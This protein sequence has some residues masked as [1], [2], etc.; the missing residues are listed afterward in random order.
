V[1]DPFPRQ[2]RRGVFDHGEARIE[3]QAG[4]TIEAR[5]NPRPAFFGRPGLRR[6][7]R[8]D[9]LDSTYFVGYAMWNYM[10]ARCRS[11]PWCGSSCAISKSTGERR[12][13]CGRSWA[14]RPP[15]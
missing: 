11:R 8:W 15:P 10:T 3:S 12:A 5:A 4:E 1:F 13:V 7:L 2:G 6:N 9:A 14:R